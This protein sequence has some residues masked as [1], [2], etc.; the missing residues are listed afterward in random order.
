MSDRQQFVLTLPSD[1]VHLPA[2]RAF[3][4]AVCQVA[5]LDPAAI[6]AVA[7]AVHEAL[8]NVIRHAHQH[9]SD[10]PLEIHCLTGAGAIEV[11]ILDEGEPFDLAAMPHLD[12]GEVRI[13]GRGLFLMRALTD[14]LSCQPRGQR[15]NVLRMVK[16][17]AGKP[18][19]SGD[20]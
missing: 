19:A 13:G 12:P 4:S 9:R 11:Q 16:R 5:E 17:S 20:A 10:V 8:H 7:L 1:A 15:G 6:D 3:L 2:A 14:E 18:N